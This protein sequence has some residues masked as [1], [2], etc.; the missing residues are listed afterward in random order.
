M[1]KYVLR[2]FVYMIVTL[3]VIVTLTFVLMH[4]IPG[5]PFVSNKRLPEAVR[6]NLMAKYGLDQPL[7]KQYG[8]YLGNLLQGDLGVSM[9]YTTRTVGQVIHDGFPVSLS[10][11]LRALLFAVPAGLALGVLAALNRARGWDY[12][13]MVFAV[14]GVAAPSFVV[15]AVLQW[16]VG[17][18]W[19]LLPVA[20][21]DGSLAKS[22]LPCFA[23]SLGIIAGVARMMRASMLDVVNQDYIKTARA[24]GL[25]GREVV[26]RHTLRN[27]MLPIITILGPTVIG[28]ITGTLVVEQIF[29]IPGLGKYYAQSITD[30]DYTMIL[31]TTVFYSALLVLTLF[32]V[33]LCYGVIDPRIRL[34]KGGRA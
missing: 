32:L 9:H 11:G 4:A 19:R 17:V 7:W 21:W 33:D 10:L 25:S 29:A 15:G 24:K 30:M 3:W 22:I 5:D 1:I 27:A 12:A 13:A 31:G 16:L 26:W 28:V 20:G 6:H 18:K 2:R 8:I 14:I 34:V 23:L